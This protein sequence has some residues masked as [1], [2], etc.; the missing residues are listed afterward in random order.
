MGGSNVT[1]TGEWTYEAVTV[2]E[3]NVIYDWGNPGVSV[4][5]RYKLP[6]DSQGYVNGQRY[7]VDA[8]EYA[9]VNTFDAYG[10]INGRYT[11]SGWTDPNKGVMGDSNVTITG[12]WT[13]EAVTVEEH[14]V[15][16]DWG[17]PDAAVTAR[18]K[19][20]VDSQGYVNGQGY[21]VD[22]SE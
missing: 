13:Y 22:G 10:N 19:L 20:P 5:S 14:N 18:Y 7:E 1:I 21:E 11:F 9:V 12:E 16:Y 8:T 6:V 2:E 17:T 4:T 15:I 3:H